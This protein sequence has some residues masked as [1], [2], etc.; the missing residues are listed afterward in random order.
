MKNTKKRILVKDADANRTIK[1]QKSN[2]EL[3]RGEVTEY[4]TEDKTYQDTEVTIFHIRADS[5]KEDTYI[6]NGHTWKNIQ[7]KTTD[8]KMVSVTLFLED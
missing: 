7:A 5:V 6:R 3:L 4:W 2:L 8:G 1:T